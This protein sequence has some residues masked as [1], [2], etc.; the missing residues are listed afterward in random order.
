MVRSTAALLQFL[1][2][3]VRPAEQSYL[4][5]IRC[6]NGAWVCV[7]MYNSGSFMM[8]SGND[9]IQS[10]KGGGAFDEGSGSRHRLSDWTR[11]ALVGRQNPPHGA[12]QWRTRPG[13]RNDPGLI[14]EVKGL[15][16]Q[17]EHTGNTAG[18]GSSFTIMTRGLLEVVR[19]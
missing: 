3:V 14:R 8:D 17:M 16:K 9:R 5:F 12:W 10:R 2:G 18:R 1:R 11:S 19:F 15:M 4:V 6:T 13:D 7:F